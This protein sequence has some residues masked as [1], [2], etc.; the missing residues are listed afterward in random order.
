MKFSKEKNPSMN[1]DCKSDTNN[2]HKCEWI[3]MTGKILKLVQN[4][5][6]PVDLVKVE[7]QCFSA[8]AVASL[9]LRGR[10]FDVLL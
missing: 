4:V 6:G 9:H 1:C 2:I 7:Y 8:S 5:A 3:I 10:L